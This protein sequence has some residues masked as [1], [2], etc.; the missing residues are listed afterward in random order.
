MNNPHNVA[1]PPTVATAPAKLIL[2]GEHAV[3]YGRPAIALPLAS[4]RARASV[5]QARRG[6]GTV[7]HARD[8][9]RSWRVADEPANPLSEQ[10]TQAWSCLA[11][12]SAG[13]A[14][15]LRITIRST[16]PI[17]SGMGSGAAVA[18]A[19]V[20]ALAAHIGRELAPAELSALVYAS[21]QRLHGTP[22]GIDNTVIAY[23]R[24]IWFV[25]PRT[26][27][28][29]PTTK[30]EAVAA[31]TLSSLV[32]GPSSVPQIEPI[33]I[34]APLTLLVGDTGIRSAT[35]APVGEVRRR[36]Q[37][38]PARYE[39]L[40]D[41]AAA[42]ASQVRELLARGDVTPIG[43]LLNQNHALLQAIG[44][45]SPELDALVT[46]ARA[47]GALGAKLSGGGWGGVMLAL[48]TPET[49]AAVARALVAAR[50]KRVLETVVEPAA[51]SIAGKDT[52]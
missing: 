27:D 20:R 44:V 10:F 38:E 49:Q 6:S 47:A 8:L 37:A 41:Q 1:Q 43:A 25:R 42:L 18:T 28:E 36:W 40:F 4:I 46:A 30:G 24:P 35:R 5:A 48:V 15:D 33:A 23:E 32:I 34:A 17:A 39:A 26:N 31:D 22:S 12:D 29:R 16:I 13:Q 7:L 45:S 50:A 21:E 19:L 2:C 14:P 51:G 52:L 11:A 3:V 9:H